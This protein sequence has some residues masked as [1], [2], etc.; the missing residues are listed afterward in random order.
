MDKIWFICG[1]GGSGKDTILSKLHDEYYLPILPTYSNR[2]PRPDEVSIQYRTGEEI[3]R[4]YG[5]DCELRMYVHKEGRVMYCTS[6]KDVREGCDYL[7]CGPSDM[8]QKFLKLFP[9][10][11]II[12]V[13]IE[14]SRENRLKRMDSREVKEAIRRVDAD[15]REWIDEFRNEIVIDGNRE[16]KEVYGDVSKILRG[17]YTLR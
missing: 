11:E 10:K 2:T 17:Y 16:F 13:I 8:Y 15:D 14:V 3:F 9:D 4:M 1:K 5:D 6:R 12:P 7:A